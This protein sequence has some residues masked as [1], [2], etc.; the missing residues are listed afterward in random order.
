MGGG[1]QVRFRKGLVV[2]QVSLKLLLLVG[3]GLFVRSLVPVFQPATWFHSIWIPVL[4]VIL[5]KER[6]AP[7]ET[8]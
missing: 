8:Q 2:A 6:R 3:A 1:A 4:T 5:P 7:S